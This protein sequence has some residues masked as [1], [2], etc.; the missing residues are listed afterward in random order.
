M[1]DDHNDALRNAD[2]AVPPLA[3]E[4]AAFSRREMV[5]RSAFART[6]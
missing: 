6:R 5:R 4:P 1:T 3:T 2:Q